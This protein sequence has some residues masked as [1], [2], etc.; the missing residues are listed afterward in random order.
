MIADES[1]TFEGSISTSSVASSVQGGY[2]QRRLLGAEEVV[3]EESG[4]DSL[5]QVGEERQKQEQA[6]E[7]AR[8]RQEQEERARKEK[9]MERE[10]EELKSALAHAQTAM[11]RMQAERDGAV[12][13]EKTM[14]EEVRAGKLED[15]QREIEAELQRTREYR[16]MLGIWQ[17]TLLARM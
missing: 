2:Y 7:E 11:K 16:E 6:I 9:E 17:E 13:A 14:R 10:A 12:L 8:K 1:F 15:V 5:D 4:R 3:V